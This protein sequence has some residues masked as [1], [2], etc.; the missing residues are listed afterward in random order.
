MDGAPYRLIAAREN[1]VFRV[2]AAS[3][4]V[5]MRLHRPGYRRDAELRSELDWM[6]A[7]ARGGL[8]VPAPVLSA[9]G[10]AMQVVDG[11]RVDVL[12]WMPGAPL[13]ANNQPLDHPDRI[14]L[15]TA[16]G[17]QMARF[18]DLCD[19]WTPPAH[20][21]R[22]AWD[23]AGLVGDTPLW[24]RFWESPDLSG[25]DRILFE[26][27]RHTANDRLTAIESAH[28]YGLIH[29]DLVRENI[30]V[31]GSALGFIDFDDGG[32]GFRLFDVATAL[33]PNLAEPDYDRLRAALLGGYRSLRLLDTSA[34]PLFLA[35]RAL[36]YVGWLAQRRDQPGSSQRSERLV[37]RARDLSQSYLDTMT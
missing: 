36:T 12:T 7:A 27:L 23:R 21:Q 19:A 8:R 3:G 32:Y 28:D 16:L 17:R 11:T 24:G 29:A 5:A 10:G 34:L 37:S 18:H 31:D 1:Q 33:L 25:D 15:F 20:F 14:G 13:G 22:C 35:L 2:D 26:T 30:M 4:P 6:A 9:S